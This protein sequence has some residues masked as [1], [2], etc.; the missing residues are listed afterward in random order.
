MAVRRSLVHV[1]DKP[2]AKD[3]VNNWAWYLEAL[4]DSRPSLSSCVNPGL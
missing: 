4:L 2:V 3:R 1:N